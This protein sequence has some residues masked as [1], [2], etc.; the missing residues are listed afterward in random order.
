MKI[1]RFNELNTAKTMDLEKH[2][3]LLGNRSEIATLVEESDIPD[4]VFKEKFFQ[5][6]KRMVANFLRVGDPSQYYLEEILNIL[7][8][9]G[10]D[11]EDFK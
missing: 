7:E 5:N 8:S 9:Y 2:K 10:S 6:N 3:N 11:V 4:D 1:F